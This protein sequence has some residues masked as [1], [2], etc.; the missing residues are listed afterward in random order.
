MAVSTTL[1]IR[2]WVSGGFLDNWWRVDKQKHPTVHKG[3]QGC[4]IVVGSLS[5]NPTHT[6]LYEAWLMPFS[7]IKNA[8]SG[9][10]IGATPL[11][12]L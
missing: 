4:F 7:G 5:A 1:T 9:F 12:S 11:K 6:G 8:P 3:G 10:V 2:S